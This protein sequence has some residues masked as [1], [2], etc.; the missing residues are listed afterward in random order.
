[1][2]I[3]IHRVITEEDQKKY[4][5]LFS[6]YI[7]KT[8]G[9]F[10]YRLSQEDIPNE[11]ER[12]GIV[13][14]EIKEKLKPKYSDVKVFKI[15]ERVY[16]EHFTVR[17]EKV[18]IRSPEELT[19]SMIQSP[20]DIEATYRRK[21]G[22]EFYGQTVNIV[23]TCN[24]ENQLNLITDISVHANNIDDSKEL[25]ERIDIVKEKTPELKE[26]H[27]DGAY[28]SK[29]NDKKFEEHTITPVQ[30]AIRG[31]DS[32]GVEVKIEQIKEDRYSVSCPN[33]TVESEFARERFKAEFNLSIGSSCAFASVCQLKT[34]K[35]SKVY[36]FTP[37]EYFKRKRIENIQKIPKER[38]S[39]RTNIE[40]T[41]SE[42]TRKMNNRKLRV[43]GSFKAQLFAYSV[44]IGVNFGRIYRYI[45]SQPPEMVLIST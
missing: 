3:R 35:K 24:P 8:S 41:I 1:M 45:S 7:K 34:K 11:Y 9:Q 20:D 17:E 33:Q 29:D 40:A 18:I 4:E 36:Y 39:L 28:S 5:E 19:S 26:L 22:K 32:E 2:L 27:F 15:F 12:I 6:R 30:T 14:K 42:F 10:L 16:K 31:R 38:R 43:R 23:E 25:N 37:E 21:H 44:G 13:Y